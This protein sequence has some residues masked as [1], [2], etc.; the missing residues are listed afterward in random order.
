MDCR[1]SGKIRSESRRIV[2]RTLN[3][4][5][6]EDPRITQRRGDRGGSE[7][8]FEHNIR[9]R[10]GRLVSDVN[11][12]DKN[13]RGSKESATTDV[14]VAHIMPAIR[15][16]QAGVQTPHHVSLHVDEQHGPK[17]RPGRRRSGIEVLRKELMRGWR[18]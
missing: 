2:F 6:I 18:S 11:K 12:M 14:L 8:P 1:G 13:S 9:V 15:Y 17:N 4:N 10:G 7:G 5:V 16:S 3:V